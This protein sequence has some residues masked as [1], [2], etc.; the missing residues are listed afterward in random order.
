M[1]SMILQK[2]NGAA[3]ARINPKSAG[4]RS[5]PLESRNSLE[6]PMILVDGI[7]ASTWRIN[8]L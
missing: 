2:D 4:I 8:K 1:L 3:T 6:N 7:Q 5:C